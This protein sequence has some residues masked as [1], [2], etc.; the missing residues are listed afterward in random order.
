MK[1]APQ[2]PAWTVPDWP[3]PPNVHALCT[4]RQ[5]GCSAAPFD[6]FNLGDHVGDDPGAVAANRQRLQAGIAEVTPGA[7]A[8]FLQQV[9]GTEVLSLDVLG[10]RHQDADGPAPCA[11]ASVAS[12]PGRVCAIM[13]ADCLPVLL[14]NRQGSVVAAVHAGWR[15]LAGP[16]GILESTLGSFWALASSSKRQQLSK[17]KHLKMKHLTRTCCGKAWLQTRWR[18]WVPASVPGLLKWEKKCAL[19]FVTTTQPPRSIFSPSV[20]QAL[21]STWPIWL[22]WQ[23]SA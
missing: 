22:R 13:V 5:G 3:A 18:G 9:H 7:Q 19:P 8:V 2:N 12:A 16:K 20:R 15:G 6:S 17:V 1:P 21:A 10:I 23:G 4:V 14:T 11:D